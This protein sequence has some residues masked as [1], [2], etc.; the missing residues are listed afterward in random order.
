M[1]TQGHGRRNGDLRDSLAHSPP[2]DLDAEQAVLGAILVDAPRAMPAVSPLLSA[3]DFFAAKHA[4]LYEVVE[5]LYRDHAAVDDVLL[6]NAIKDRGHETD[7]PRDYLLELIETVPSGAMAEYHAGLVAEKAQARRA[8]DAMSQAYHA[9]TNGAD[10][11]HV[12]S[13]MR[14][15]IDATGN[16]PAMAPATIGKLTTDHPRLRPAVLDGLLRRGETANIIAAPKVGKSWLV[17]DLALSVATGRRWLDA[18]A[19]DPGRVLLIDNE[20]HPETIANRIPKVAEARRIEAGEYGDLIDV[21]TLRGKGVSLVD[22]QRFIDRIEA[23]QYRAIVCDA[24]YRFIPEGLNENSNADVMSLYNRLDRYAGQTDAA[25]LVVHHASKGGQGEKAITDVGAGAGAQSRA[26]DTHLILRP[27]EEDGAVVLEA[28]TRSFP[29]L[30][31]I[32]LTWEWPCWHRAYTLDTAAVRGRKTVSE[33]RQQHRDEEGKADILKALACGPLS[34]RQVR[35]A[36]GG[37]GKERAERLLDLLEAERRVRW[38]NATIRGGRGRI[39][40]RV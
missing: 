8:M 24:W 18:F 10:N 20:L 26:A 25:W 35:G 31:P 17:Y 21:L 38:E 1:K 23:G 40:E 32:G 33:E 4:T 13:A 37:M 36:A 16:R 29:P 27:H 11:E 15:A 19:T 12:F 2:H 28:A 39:Y 3:D 14:T 9:L 6:L 34:V 30:E 22:L 5:R 7:I